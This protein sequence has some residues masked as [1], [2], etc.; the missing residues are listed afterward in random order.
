MAYERPAE[1]LV[2]QERVPVEGRCAECSAE[3]LFAYPVLSE[4]GWFNA[5]KCRSCLASMRR[6]ADPVGQLTIFS[7]T[8]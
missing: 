5:V 7:T 2:T 4:G 3:Q 6:E 1:L 8:I